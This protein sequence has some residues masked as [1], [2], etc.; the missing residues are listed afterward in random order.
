MIH[1]DDVHIGLDLMPT[2][3]SADADLL[4]SLVLSCKKLGMFYYPNMLARFQEDDLPS[5]VWVSIEE[6]K[7]FDLALYKVWKILGNR[8]NQKRGATGVASQEL[9]AVELQFP[10]PKND[11]LWN[12]TTKHDWLAAITEDAEYNK[13]HDTREEEW[14]SKSAKPLGVVEFSILQSEDSEFVFNR[15]YFEHWNMLQ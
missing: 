5:Y 2:L 9:E 3:P 15:Q 13:L 11:P 7:R 6:I 14:I 8:D 12:A 4:K 10:L 1:K